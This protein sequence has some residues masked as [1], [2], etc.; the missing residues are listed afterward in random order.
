LLVAGAR[1]GAS[2]ET[3]AEPTSAHTAHSAHFDKAFI[4]EFRAVAKTP[5]AAEVLLVEE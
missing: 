4:A 2:A 1:R 5:D 3:A